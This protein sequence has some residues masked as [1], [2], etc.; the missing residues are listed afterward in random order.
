ML[1]SAKAVVR[2]VARPKMDKSSVV[3]STI[4]NQSSAQLLDRQPHRRVGIAKIPRMKDA[5]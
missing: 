5:E 2:N 4:T 1:L 3:P